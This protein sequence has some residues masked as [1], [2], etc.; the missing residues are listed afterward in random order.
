[1]QEAGTKMNGA[2][3]ERMTFSTATIAFLKAR[4]KQIVNHPLFNKPYKCLVA[5]GG[6]WQFEHYTRALQCFY[7]LI[8][9]QHDS[10]HVL[11]PVATSNLGRL[12]RC[13]EFH[14]SHT[15]YETE[16]IFQEEC[17]KAKEDLHAYAMAAERVRTPALE[18]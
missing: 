6:T 17:R 3:P 9:Q 14:T 4:A 18:P 11:H 2:C 5:C 15:V 13:A 10:G 12:R 8:F 7:A 1:M 16:A